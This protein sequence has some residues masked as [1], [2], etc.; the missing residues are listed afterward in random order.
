MYRFTEKQMEIKELIGEFAERYIRPG[1]RQRDKQG[2]YPYE[3]I[4]KLT[5]L[6]YMGNNIPKEYGGA[7]LDSV[8]AS[9]V[10]NMIS[11]AD[12]ALGHLIEVNNHGFCE[13]ILEFGTEEQRMRYLPQCTS[14]ACIGVFA[15]TEPGGSDIEN[16]KLSAIEEDDYFVLK[17]CKTMVTNAPNADYALVLARTD[18]SFGSFF[19]L[20]FF[21]VDLSLEGLN[22]G[23]TEE[24]LGQRSLNIA[25]INFDS[26]RVSKDCILGKKHEGIMILIKMMETMRVSVSAMALGIAQAAL[27]EAMKFSRIPYR[28]DRPMHEVPVIKMYIAEMVAKVKTMEML[29]YNTAEMKKDKDYGMNTLVT[30]LM[31]T[32]FAKEV[33]DI[34]LQIH[35]GCGYISDYNI[36]RFYRDVRGTTIFG[37]SS[38]RC[39]VTIAD[40]YLGNC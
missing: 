23:K 37:L 28:N 19:G 25:D 18:E 7:G 34:A 32:E 29:V 4:G 22:I 24:T 33:C 20:T 1:A 39:K 11:Q 13:P 10:I 2:L 5:E 16:I 26:C 36:E 31:V 3:I 9:I 21:I 27:Q 6:G 38:E 15:Y 35:G 30:K 17:G 40:M 8:S 14:G 12:S